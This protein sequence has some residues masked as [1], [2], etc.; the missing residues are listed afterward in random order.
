MLND[1][2]KAMKLLIEIDEFA[3][4]ADAEQWNAAPKA[5]TEKVG[6]RTPGTIS[7]PTGELATDQNRLGLR[8][9]I[10]LT[11]RDARLLVEALERMH[12]RLA[13]VTKPY[14]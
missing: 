9:E 5:I 8:R 7:D 4:K 3:H 6:N 10:E 2:A 1:L 11:T 13:K 14:G 12:Y